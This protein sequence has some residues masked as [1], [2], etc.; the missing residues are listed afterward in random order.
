MQLLYWKKRV[1]TLQ[2]EIQVLQ[3]FQWSI[4]GSLASEG[5]V[6]ASNHHQLALEEQI[7]MEAEEIIR[8]ER[9]QLTALME[10]C[11]LLMQQVHPSHSS[12]YSLDDR[13]RHRGSHSPSSGWMR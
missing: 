3:T 4:S 7:R 11:R 8:P 12:F 9:S 13:W 1:L 5:V 6:L 10:D 2:A